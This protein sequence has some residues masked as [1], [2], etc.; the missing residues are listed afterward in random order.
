MML[1]VKG[2]LLATVF[3]CGYGSVIMMTLGA[4]VHSVVLFAVG[5]VLAVAYSF[6]Q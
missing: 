2:I 5:V 3:I 6:L 4:P 1:I